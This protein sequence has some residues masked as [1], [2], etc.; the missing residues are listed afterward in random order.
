VIPKHNVT[1]DK[2]GYLNVWCLGL[3]VFIYPS[4]IWSKMVNLEYVP[5]IVKESII[6]N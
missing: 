3:V 6:G 5:E 2:G 1:V 4:E